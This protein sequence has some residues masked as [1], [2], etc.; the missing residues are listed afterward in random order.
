M[1]SV[2]RS[3]FV[4]NFKPIRKLEGDMRQDVFRCP[5]LSTYIL[6]YINW[7]SELFRDLHWYLLTF[8]HMFTYVQRW[9]VT[10]GHRCSQMITRVHNCSKIFTDVH[11]CSKM[12]IDGHRWSQMFTDVQRCLQTFTDGHW[13]SWCHYI[14]VQ[15]GWCPQMFTDLQRWS[16]SSPQCAG[17]HLHLAPALPH[18]GRPARGR[19][20]THPTSITRWGL[21]HRN[22]EEW[23]LKFDVVV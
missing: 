9:S 6:T 21:P 11:R 7:C 16:L 8:S 18:L 4:P 5:Q 19:G 10:I 13:C 23:K 3:F 17:G 14:N 12:F 20:G 1:L 15:V 2:N 22:I